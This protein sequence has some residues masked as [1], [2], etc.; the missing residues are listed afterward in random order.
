MDRLLV[1]QG[2]YTEQIEEGE[3]T[4]REFLGKSSVE[5]LLVSSSLTLDPNM[6]PTVPAAYTLLES[7]DHAKD[8]VSRGSPLNDW[9]FT[10]LVENPMLRNLQRLE[11]SRLVVSVSDRVK[12]AGPRLSISDLDVQYDVQRCAA[13]LQAHRHCREVFNDEFDWSGEVGKDAE[14]VLEEAQQEVEEAEKLLAS[15]PLRDVKEI[16]SHK[17][18]TFHCSKANGFSISISHRCFIPRLLTY[19]QHSAK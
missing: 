16:I 14:Q 3:L 15:F 19:R 2:S 11:H 7:V 8:A 6:E 12:G 17:F 13:F 9:T 18:C 1:S 4:G 5:V 10:S